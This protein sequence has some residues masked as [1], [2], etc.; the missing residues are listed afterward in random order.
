MIPPHQA[1]PLP[2]R[3]NLDNYK[4]LAKGLVKASKS[5][6][7]SA[8]TDWIP[9]W[10]GK[11]TEGVAEFARRQLAGHATLAT[12]Q[13]VI[14]R[15]HGFES[16]PKFAHHLQSLNR[17]ASS[18]SNFEAAADAIANGDLDTLH[19]LLRETPALIRVTSTRAHNAT[20]LHY[21]A[22]NGVEDHR[23]KTPQNI[24]EITN[25]LLD[26][27]AAIDASAN[28]YGGGITTLS[29]AATSVL[30]ERAGV[31]QPLLRTLLD[32]GARLPPSIVSACLANG[33]CKAAEFLATCGA[34]IDFVEAAGLGRL[35]LV[36]TLFD[37]E[38]QTEALRYASAY[39]RDSVV[40][41]LLERRVDP[42]TNGRDGQTALHWAVI[43]GHP[44]TVALLLRHNAPLEM[45][46]RY[47]GTPLG[48]ALWSAAHGGIAE[49]YL[50]ILKLFVNGGAKLPARHVP[51]NPAVDSW[52]EARGSQ[53]DPTL[54][55]Y[56]E[57]PTT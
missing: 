17:C 16:W 31:Q 11:T 29:L 48:Q 38:R 37:R 53:A 43:G 30:P 23:Q 28:L 54:H 10:L 13:F 46:N 25:L 20:L 45:E 14:A 34:S 12:A 2:P 21:V 39:G 36:E 47:R 9:Q 1:L 8:V 27:G 18:V 4:K 7:P 26:A 41:Y 22:A 35:E 5:P 3:P 33:R 55:W 42:A 50:T 57:Q 44:N 51:V 24:V 15:I 32:R 19:N 56:G 49:D 6:D 40:E 52:L